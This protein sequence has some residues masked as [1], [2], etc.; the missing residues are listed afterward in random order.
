MS[1]TEGDYSE[2]GKWISET[3]VRP[4]KKGKYNESI[5]EQEEDTNKKT[6]RLQAKKMVED[7]S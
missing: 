5:R 1:R 6:E 4:W 3:V 7:S 2:G